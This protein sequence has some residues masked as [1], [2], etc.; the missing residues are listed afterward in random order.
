MLP[1]SMSGLGVR[2][3]A[4]VYLFAQAGV[5]TAQA[6][7]MSLLI[8]ALRVAAGLVGGV[9]YALQGFRELRRQKAD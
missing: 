7:A 5:S 9:L 3:G 1:V 6:L 4:Y 8:Y 2:E